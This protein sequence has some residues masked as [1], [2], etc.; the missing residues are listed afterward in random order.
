MS[1][2]KA[3][4]FPIMSSLRRLIATFRDI[5][6]HNHSYYCPYDCLRS[7]APSLSLISFSTIELLT[8]KDQVLRHSAFLSVQFSLIYYSCDTRVSLKITQYTFGGKKYEKP[9]HNLNSKNKTDLFLIGVFQSEIIFLGHFFK[10]KAHLKCLLFVCSSVQHTNITCI[11]IH[12][13]KVCHLRKGCI[14][15]LVYKY[16]IPKIRKPLCEA[17]AKSR[18]NQWSSTWQDSSW[19]VWVNS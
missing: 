17:N 18:W 2:W 10:K 3:T 16:N 12:L 9:W 19:G 1:R 6:C 14:H 11:K 4:I 15:S 13:I 7:L 5:W 8:Q